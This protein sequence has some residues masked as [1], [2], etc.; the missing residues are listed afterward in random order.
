MY[1]QEGQGEEIQAG[2]VLYHSPVS[3]F[4]AR[5]SG[6]SPVTVL[7]FSSIS[8]DING[9]TVSPHFSRGTSRH[10]NGANPAGLPYFAHLDRQGQVSPR[11]RRQ[12]RRL[13][14]GENYE[15]R[16]V[17]HGFDSRVAPKV[18]EADPLH[19]ATNKYGDSEWT[20]ADGGRHVKIKDAVVREQGKDA[21]DNVEGRG[22]AAE[23]PGV[24]SETTNPPPLHRPPPLD[25]VHSPRI[26][27][28]GVYAN[29]ERGGCSG[30]RWQGSGSPPS[31]GWLR[32]LPDVAQE[33]RSDEELDQGESDFVDGGHALSLSRLFAYA[34]PDNDQH[35]R[36]L[37]EPNR[38]INDHHGK[39]L[40]GVGGSM[41]SACSLMDTAGANMGSRH[42]A[43]SSPQALPGDNDVAATTNKKALLGVTVRRPPSPQFSFMAECSLDANAPAATSP[44]QLA[45]F[46]AQE[47]EVQETSCV[48]I[49]DQRAKDVQQKKTTPRRVPFGTPTNFDD[50]ADIP[51][52][53]ASI[54]DETAS[55]QNGERSPLSAG[56]GRKASS[57]GT[58]LQVRAPPRSRKRKLPV[59]LTAR[60][61]V[62]PRDSP[63]LPLAMDCPEDTVQK[64][65]LVAG[66]HG[67]SALDKEGGVG[68][69]NGWLGQTYIR[70]RA[71]SGWCGAKGDATVASTG[72]ETASYALRPF[73]MDNGNA[74][75]DEH[76]VSWNDANRK[77]HMMQKHVGGGAPAARYEWAKAIDDTRSAAP[78]AGSGDTNVLCGSEVST[79]SEEGRKP[80][81]AA[82]GGDE[83][84]YAEADGRSGA[85]DCNKKGRTRAADAALA[86]DQ[87]ELGSDGLAQ[88]NFVYF[89]PETV[90][91]VVGQFMATEECNRSDDIRDYILL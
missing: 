2:G 22:Y 64:R 13:A 5:D 36:R 52:A 19:A 37:P 34:F 75:F 56:A 73:Q 81:I 85:G 72:D 78:G 25:P 45:P 61:T 32:Y 16:G 23:A 65:P 62:T 80:I 9:T 60:R 46:K 91:D 87:D 57:S 69:G 35:S 88:D 17:S 21:C 38:E 84:F 27:N 90:A 30:R 39:V 54:L 63:S 31:G 77:Y 33:M 47:Q 12:P 76:E 11:E 44:R 18:I 74:E 49:V 7:S 24:R 29:I 8:S 14:L 53:L 20:A 10:P 86:Y 26:A 70:G 15:G 51:V 3:C 41:Q 50:N 6:Q 55:L 59:S 67:A 83:G 71:R 1:L 48:S 82:A 66:D 68:L 89:E 43:S 42:T 79:R 40:S 4:G 58:G 28:C